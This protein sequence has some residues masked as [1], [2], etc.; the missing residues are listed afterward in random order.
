M[1]FSQYHQHHILPYAKTRN[2]V[3]EESAHEH[4]MS[5]I[6]SAGTSSRYVLFARLHRRRIFLR[7]D[8]IHLFCN[9]I[10]RPRHGRHLWWPLNRHFQ[11]NNCHGCIFWVTSDNCYLETSNWDCLEGSVVV[12]FTFNW[13]HLNPSR[14]NSKDAYPISLA[15]YAW[16]GGIR[17]GPRELQIVFER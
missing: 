1:Y 17:H 8:Q 7:N 3:F 4:E 15:V 13:V 12:S 11:T 10:F 14:A 2:F 16:E 6:E 5:I 9:L